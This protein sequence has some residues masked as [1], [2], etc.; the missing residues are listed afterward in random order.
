MVGVNCK[1]NYRSHSSLLYL[2]NCYDVKIFPSILGFLNTEVCL[3]RVFSVQNEKGVP[4]KEGNKMK[5]ADRYILSELVGPL[6]LAAVGFGLFML[7]NIVFLLVDQIVTKQVPWMAV[8]EMLGLRIPA[9]LVLTF[10]VAMLFATLLGLGRLVAD[11]EIIAMRTSGISFLRLTYPILGLAILLVFL[12]FL[13][14]EKISP[15]AT[16]RSE[17]IIREILLRQ[18]IPPVEP[19]VFIHGPNNTVYYV[20]ALDKPNR[21]LYHVM[22]YEG[23]GSLYPRM[24]VADRAEYDGTHFH[25]YKGSIHQYAPGG[26]TQYESSFDEMVVPVAINPELFT[27]SDKSS[28]EMSATELRKQ[29]GVLKASGIE[30][31]VMDTDYYF[32]YSLPFGCLVAGL[33]GIPL[34]VRFPRGGR[35][36]SIA[37]GV[38][39]LFIYYCL[40]SVSRALGTVGLLSPWIAAWLPNLLLGGFGIFFLWREELIR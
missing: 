1:K 6:F 32:K 31:R 25:L 21:M 37:S 2:I 12:T 33:I 11:H 39:L 26:L 20:G 34:G 10:P 7:A 18:A 8:I 19:N 4:T 15:W 35:F 17:T 16:H 28:F 24:T 38:F 40:F 14:N 36:I 13:T 5:L 3:G 30:T 23:S 22:I 9:I 27:T 29:I